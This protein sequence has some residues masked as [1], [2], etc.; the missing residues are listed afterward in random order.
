MRTPDQAAMMHNLLT[1]DLMKTRATIFFAAMAMI[2]G[3]M[4]VGTAL[5]QGKLE[6]ELVV[7]SE[8]HEELLLMLKKEFQKLHPETDVIITNMD[9]SVSY[10][11]SF[12]EMPNPQADILTT[13]KYF[14]IQGLADSQKMLGY[15][16][17]E[18]Y[19]SPERKRLNPALLDKEGYYQ[20]ERWGARA[21]LYH[22]AAEKKHG[23]IDSF[24]DLLK[25][26]GTFDYPNPIT[27][28]AGFSA[29][30][31]MIQDFPKDKSGTQQEIWKR[32]YE[33]P[34]GGVEY[35]ALLKKAH[36]E[37][38]HAGTSPMGQQFARGDIDAMWNFDIWYY[39][40]VIQDGMKIKAVYPKEGTIISTNDVGILKNCQHPKAARAWIDF[41]L[42]KPIQT[43]FMEKTYYRTAAKD[44]P[45]PA[46]MKKIEISHPERINLEVDEEYVAKRT[47]EYKALWEEKVTK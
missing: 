31:T 5:A 21:I 33:N 46:A 14:F 27:T 40:G 16:M 22:A 39:Q 17:F 28:G 19:L 3:F 20:T 32:G 30:Q 37:M 1:E 35:A 4:S 47:K 15:P 43:L 26:K 44:V 8:G 6:K 25:W 38:S 10:K 34:V 29:I 2:L 36:P 41:V 42:S 11:K 45:I 9:S 23:P 13:K 7:R 24:A 12:S 18:K